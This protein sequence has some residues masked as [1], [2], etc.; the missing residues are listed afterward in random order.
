MFSFCA[1]KSFWPDLTAG[2]L[3]TL[4]PRNRLYEGCYLRLLHP[5]QFTTTSFF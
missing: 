1:S 2:K 3:T 5:H 4:P